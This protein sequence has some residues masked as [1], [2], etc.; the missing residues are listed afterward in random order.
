MDYTIAQMHAF[1]HAVERQESRRMANLLTLIAHGSHGTDE[2][3]R[4]MIRDLSC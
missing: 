4:K 3:I 2:V 1:T